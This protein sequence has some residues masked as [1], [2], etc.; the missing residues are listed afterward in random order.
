MV[1]QKKTACH[2]RHK[3]TAK[4]YPPTYVCN[5]MQVNSQFAKNRY[6]YKYLVKNSQPNLHHLTFA[7]L[8][9]MK[10]LRE[11]THADVQTQVWDK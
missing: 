10:M 5:Q 3:C 9:H 4:F 6:H 7:F 2:D 1:A 11:Y 8:P